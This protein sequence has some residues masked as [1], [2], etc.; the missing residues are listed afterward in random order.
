MTTAK[1]IIKAL[2]MKPLAVEGGYYC[3]TYRA[4]GIIPKD[5][6]PEQY[7]SDRSF[8]TAILYLIDRN[9]SSSLHRIKS[10]EVFHFYMGDPVTMLQ[11]LPDGSSQ[12]ITLGQ[13][14]TSGQ[15]VQAV[16]PANTWQGCF[17]NDGGEFA[18]MGT[19][20]TPGFEFEDF[21]SADRDQLLQ[22][23]PDQ[24][25]LILRLTR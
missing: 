6:L 4:K 18:L 7:D 12:V 25:E 11:L 8:G 1:E 3:E 2:G 13:D 9:T 15:Q 19:T 14:I 5:V 17:V 21:E 16:V 22:Q 10:D 24:Q 20:V 23:Y